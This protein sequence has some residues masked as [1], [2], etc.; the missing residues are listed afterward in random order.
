MSKPSSFRFWKFIHFS[1]INQSSGKTWMASSTLL[2]TG[3]LEDLLTKSFE[4]KERRAS[5]EVLW[6][7]GQ[8]FA[9]AKILLIVKKFQELLQVPAFFFYSFSKRKR[10]REID[11]INQMSSNILKT[12]FQSWQELWRTFLNKNLN[13]FVFVNT[14]A[15]SSIYFNKD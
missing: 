4:E 1:I 5:F 12:I 13:V 3:M 9:Q 14:F 8:W 6:I 15:L 7:L 11:V 2:M 10:E